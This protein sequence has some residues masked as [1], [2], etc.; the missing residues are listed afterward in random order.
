MGCRYV[1]ILKRDNDDI[2]YNSDKSLW[3]G[4]SGISDETPGFM[5]VLSEGDMRLY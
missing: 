3:L 1:L 5:P 4:I 2:V